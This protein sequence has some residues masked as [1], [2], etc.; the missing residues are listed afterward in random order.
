MIAAKVKRRATRKTP[1]TTDP[2]TVSKSALKISTWPAKSWAVR[3]Q[4]IARVLA[5]VDKTGLQLE[6]S[7]DDVPGDP[8]EYLIAQAAYV[9]KI[10]PRLTY[11]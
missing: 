3:N 7:H 10:I 11:D 2:K 9:R 4:M 1:R 5:Y 8:D 6:V